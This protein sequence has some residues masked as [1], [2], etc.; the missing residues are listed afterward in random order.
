MCMGIWAIY[1]VREAV[2]ILLARDAHNDRK[3][4]RRETLEARTGRRRL[5]EDK[6]LLSERG[7]TVSTSERKRS[8]SARL[9][10][11][12][13]I[14]ILLAGAALAYYETSGFFDA[15]GTWYGPMRITSG[16][17]TVSVETYMDLSTSLTG[18]L[19]GQ[20][21]FCLP[22][23]FSDTATF[24]F[25]LTGQHAFT[26]WGYGPQPPIALTL[27]ETVPVILG[28]RVPIG[29]QLQL[30]GSATSSTLHLLGGDQSVATVLDMHHGSRAT[31]TTACHSLAPLS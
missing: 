6:V 13:V 24:N 12:L 29:P 14:L 22:L 17:V 27:D 3:P 18:H 4:R 30:H 25:T 21:T 26:L 16:S 8:A 19:S 31:F 15:N 23:P 20:G 10:P 9:V 28:V 11:L 7:H 1:A 2:G 5:Q